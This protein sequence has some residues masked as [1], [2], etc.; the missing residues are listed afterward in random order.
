M[1]EYHDEPGLEYHVVAHVHV[2]A[3]QHDHGL[4]AGDPPAD[5]LLVLPPVHLTGLQG[6]QAG[7]PPALVRVGHELVEDVVGASVL[8]QGALD[9]G[10]N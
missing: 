7:R 8:G 4:P 5:V 6:E 3:R 1:R 9:C 10:L 2:L